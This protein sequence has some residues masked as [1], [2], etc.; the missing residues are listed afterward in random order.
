MRQLHDR[1]TTSRFLLSTSSRRPPRR[2]TP[3]G[4]R[5]AGPHSAL[6]H[7]ITFLSGRK[8]HPHT[9]AGRGH[10][11]PPRSPVRTCAPMRRFSAIPP[12]TTCNGMMCMPC[13]ATSAMAEEEPNGNLKVTLHGQT[14]VLHPP[15]APRM[16]A[17]P[18]GTHGAAALSECAATWPRPPSP[19]ASSAAAGTAAH[20]L[21]V[22]DH[23]E[24]RI[25][26]HGNGRGPTSRSGSGSHGAWAPTF[27]ARRTTR[28]TFRA[29][30]GESPSPIAFFEPVALR[31]D[32]HRPGARLRSWQ[33][34]QQ[35]NGPV[36]R[37]GE[38]PSSGPG[39]D[40]SSAPWS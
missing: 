18:G 19:A 31:A 9:A 28:R 13:S 20:W 16:S 39:R 17:P 23:H 40:A 25:F 27:T 2:V 7:D 37:V 6:T 15:R 24:A 21:L 3:H 29:R 30:Q 12:R 10:A 35:R 4:L 8:P 11:R 14:L 34:Q 26:P 33:G 22:I 32:R 36:H 38:S 1:Y 5:A